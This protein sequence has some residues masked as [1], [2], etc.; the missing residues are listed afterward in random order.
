MKK[1]GNRREM[2]R[3]DK[4]RARGKKL[5]RKEM[6]KIDDNNNEEIKKRKKKNKDK[7]YDKWIEADVG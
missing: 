6:W 4:N 7:N 3:K 1:E 5:K 2:K